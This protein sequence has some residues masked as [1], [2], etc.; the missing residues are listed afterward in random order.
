M[1]TCLEQILCG[2]SGAVL[3]ALDTVLAAQ[4]AQLQAQIAALEAEILVLDVATL[5]VEAARSG[6]LAL[7]NQARAASGFIPLDLIA[8]CAALGD[9]NV[10]LDGALA[11]ATRQVND[12]VDDLN[13]LLS[14]RE[15]LKLL[16]L[17]FTQTIEVFA[18]IEL[19]IQECAQAA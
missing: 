10:S 5:P 1:A 7:L 4:R 11:A 19:T 3:G 14:Y 12:L 13:R 9:F 2:L 18:Q 15:E 6:A 16:V 17:K 8:G